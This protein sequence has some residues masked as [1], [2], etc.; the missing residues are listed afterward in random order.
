MAD[1]AIVDP[2]ATVEVVSLASGALN[3]VGDLFYILNASAHLQR[4]QKVASEASYL[5]AFDWCSARY[6]P[7]RRDFAFGRERGTTPFFFGATTV[8]NAS[9]GAGATFGTF[10]RA[11]KNRERLPRRAR[12]SKYSSVINADIFSASAVETSWLMEIP[13]RSARSRAR[14][15][16]ELGNRRLKALIRPLPSREVLAESPPAFAPARRS[17]RCQQNAADCT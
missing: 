5:S 17:V 3:R 11:R 16:R 13:S 15:W 12:T 7:S 6:A 8:G 10:A 2:R 1:E 4:H 14:S 9:S